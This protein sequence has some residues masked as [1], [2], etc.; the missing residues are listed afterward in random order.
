[1]AQSNWDNFRRR[2]VEKIDRTYNKWLSFQTLSEFTP[3]FL[4][5]RSEAYFH[6]TRKNKFAFSRPWHPSA[7]HLYHTP[8]KKF[9]ASYQR[10]KINYRAFL[11]GKGYMFETCLYGKLGTAN[12]F[13]L[14]VGTTFSWAACSAIFCHKNFMLQFLWKKRRHFWYIFQNR[15]DTPQCLLRFS[16]LTLIFYEYLRTIR[17]LIVKL[18]W[19][20]GKWPGPKFPVA[21]KFWPAS[22]WRKQL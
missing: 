16:T 18:R 1:M 9:S 5:E 10:K 12:N 4:G 6:K 20:E 8:K 17:S 15:F 19:Q 11:K 22:F 14:K 2:G 21:E 7:F 13:A 3:L